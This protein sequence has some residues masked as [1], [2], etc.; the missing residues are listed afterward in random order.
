MLK[1]SIMM[2]PNDRKLGLRFFARE[3]SYAFSAS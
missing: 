1:I 3:S 2:K